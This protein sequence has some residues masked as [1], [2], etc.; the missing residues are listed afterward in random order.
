MLVLHVNYFIARNLAI[1]CGTDGEAFGCLV[2]RL[3]CTRFF[4]DKTLSYRG[5]DKSL[6]RPTS[7][8]I[9]FDGENISFDA[10]LVLYI[11]IQGG[12]GGMDQTSGGCSLC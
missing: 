12:T 3:V 11:Y 9:L 6:A 1:G 5:V 4:N 2:M 8:F 10:S 7:R